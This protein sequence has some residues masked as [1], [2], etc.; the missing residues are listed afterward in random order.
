MKKKRIIF[1][2]FVL[3]ILLL[4]FSPPA[5]ALWK[6]FALIG[7]IFLQEEYK[8]LKGIEVEKIEVN[9]KSGEKEFVADVY[10]PN[11]PTKNAVII[12]TPLVG[13]ARED[14]A[15]TN[16]A[17]TFAK[18]GI[19]AFIPFEKE[20]KYG[21]VNEEDIE[22]VISAFLFLKNFTQTENIGIFGIS[23]GTGPVIAASTDERIKQDVKFIFSLG[24]YYDLKNL[25]KFASTESFE[26]GEIKGKFEPHPYVKQIMQTSLIEFT[27]EKELLYSAIK[28]DEEIEKLNKESL[29]IYNILSNKEE[30]KFEEL[31]TEL[32]AELK[33]EMEKLSPKNY[34]NKL[35][36]TKIFIIHS[37]TDDYIPYTESLRFYDSFSEEQKR[38]T[39]IAIMSTFGHAVPKKLNLQTLFSIYLPNLRKLLL[40]TYNF[41]IV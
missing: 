30:E 35:P 15:L 40:I 5:L 14:I 7:N 31:Y 37:P 12:Y 33:E 38:Q 8:P 19:L 22:D 11:S 20:K 25:I 21:L 16:L 18:L 4:I 39:K 29:A 1:V 27:K 9:Y 32:P 36:E 41:M 17:E 24:G 13:E 23:Y 10:L 2:V 6:S 26:Y 28:G 34:I 3:V